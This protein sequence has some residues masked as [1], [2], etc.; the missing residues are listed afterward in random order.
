MSNQMVTFER[1]DLSAEQVDLIKRT[2][3]KGAT[4]D[5]LQLFVGICNRTGL[6]PFARQIYA[7]KRWDQRAGKE[8]L[9]TQVSIDGFRLVAVRSGEYAGQEGPFW[10][11][12][13]GEWKDVWINSKPPSAAKVGV[14]GKGDKSPT[15]G[16]ARFDAYA[17]LTRDGKL[18][19][20]WAKMG[21]NQLAKC[22][23]ALALRKRFPQ[24]L[25]G[26]YTNDEMEQSAPAD[27]TASGG[28]SVASKSQATQDKA[29]GRFANGKSPIP[30]SGEGKDASAAPGSGKAA[31]AN[32]GANGFSVVEPLDIEFD[33]PAAPSGAVGEGAPVSGASEKPAAQVVPGVRPNSGPLPKT[34][35]TP[36]PIGND[37][38]GSSGFDANAGSAGTKAEPKRAPTTQDP[39]RGG[40][41]SG[42]GN[43][44]GSPEGGGN[45]SSVGGA[46]G[47]GGA[48]P[49]E[50]PAINPVPKTHEEIEWFVN[51]MSESLRE[52]TSRKQLAE[53]WTTNAASTNSLPTAQKQFLIALKD[54]IKAKYP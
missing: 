50:G 19:G 33:E 29:K 32:K 17:Q 40:A 45:V 15:W 14:W 24:E 53:I 42:N 6:D 41:P 39:G 30:E 48:A 5:E 1:K 8:I 22:A 10:C 23:E 25:S 35:S 20:M 54:E 28:T 9:S 49:A 43:S 47:A 26:L 34:V 2:I 27:D 7:I 16:V 36:K 51:H 37:V 4:D 44:Q 13:N 31:G 11:G 38:Q 46:E 3:A 18:T 21:D 12:E 52:V